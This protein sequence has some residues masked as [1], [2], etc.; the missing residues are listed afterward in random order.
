MAKSK[1]VIKI[2]YDQDQNHKPNTGPEMVTVWHYNRILTT[3]SILL[4]LVMVGIYGLTDNEQTSTPAATPDTQIP[5]ATV[6]PAANIQNKPQVSAAEPANNAK[7]PGTPAEISL[8]LQPG[9]AMILD[10]S[11]LRASLNTEIKDTEPYRQVKQA[12]KLDQKQSIELFYFN[13]LKYIKVLALSH[14]WYKQGKLIYKKQFDLKPNTSRLISSKKFTKND[15]G[16]WQIQLV[17]SK[18]KVFSTLSF[19]ISYE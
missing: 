13:Q 5:E 3:F 8:T 11:V 19:K 1:V 16:D 7:L 10:R 14:A 12:I 9:N 18:T 17:D 15:V 2:N 4:V 6:P